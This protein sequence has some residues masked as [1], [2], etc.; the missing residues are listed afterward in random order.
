MHQTAFGVK[1]HWDRPSEGASQLV[2]KVNK[3]KRSAF[4]QKY[5]GEAVSATKFEV[6]PVHNN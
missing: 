1:P 4:A 2:R 3:V 6:W 5:V